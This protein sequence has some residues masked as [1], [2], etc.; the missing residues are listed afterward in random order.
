M[1]EVVATQDRFPHRHRNTLKWLER[2]RQR[3]LRVYGQGVTTDAGLSFTFEDW[4]LFDDS[5]AWREATTGT[6]AER[7]REAWRSAPARSAEEPD[8]AR[9]PG[10]QLLRPDHHHRMR[11]ARE[12]AVRRTDAAQGGAQTGK[13]PVDVMLD[14]AVSED[15]K[16]EFFAPAVNQDMELMKELI[17]RPDIPFGVCDGGAHTKFLTAGRYPTEGIVKYCPRAAVALARTDPLAAER[18]A[19]VLR[20]LQGS[21]LPARRRAGRHRGL[22]PRQLNVLPIEIAHDL[23]GN[24]WRRVQRARATSGSSSTA[25]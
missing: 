4:N 23:P 25:R 12:Q 14:L 24:E 5:D 2:C 11:E 15:L 10:H 16:T 8:A 19:R 9:E 21:R 17:D 20:R 7:T 1:Y 3:G 18:A 13:D 6:V 22:R